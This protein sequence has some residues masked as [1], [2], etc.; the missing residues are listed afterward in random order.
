MKTSAGHGSVC[1]CLELREGIAEQMR[2]DASIVKERRK[3][4]EET[5]L[6]RAPPQPKGGGKAQPK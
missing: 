5:Q 2:T 1:V 6:I 3:A 4:R